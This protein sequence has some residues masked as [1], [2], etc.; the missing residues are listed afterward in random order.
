MSRIE[1]YENRYLRDNYNIISVSRGKE[2]LL[3]GLLA[4]AS[5]AAGTAYL[6]ANQ[7]YLKK[8]DELNTPEYKSLPTRQET[9]L[10]PYND[11]ISGG[12]S[13]DLNKY[14][15][16]NNHNAGVM[17][18]TAI[19][20]NEKSHQL[21][22]YLI[23]KQIGTAINSNLPIIEKNIPVIAN[24]PMKQ[25]NTPLRL[26]NA[27]ETGYDSFNKGE[28]H[29]KKTSVPILPIRVNENYNNANKEYTRIS[30]NIGKIENTYA[31]VLPATTSARNDYVNEYR[32]LASPSILKNNK[33]LFE[34]ANRQPLNLN[35]GLRRFSQRQANAIHF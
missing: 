28:Y 5:A 14:I 25:S 18:G 26:F 13:L 31:N 1:Q 19:M 33:I 12:S 22:S 23:G 6:Y 8:S 11:Q 24:E 17:S 29:K 10:N 34:A 7:K 15:H 4:G 16:I 32:R 2:T 27:R 21:N 35:N 20:N 3:S 9:T 30:P